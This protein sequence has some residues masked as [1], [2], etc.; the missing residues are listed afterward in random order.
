LPEASDGSGESERVPVLICAG[1]PYKYFPEHDA[2]LVDIARR[3]GRCRFV[4]FGHLDGARTR[5]LLTRAGNAFASAGLRAEDFLELQ[6]WMR[7][8][9]FRRFMR[10][11]DVYLD[12]IGFSGFNTVLQALGSGLPVITHRGEFMRGRFGSGIL[13]SLSA[14]PLIADTPDAYAEI[15]ATIVTDAAARSH[16]QAHFARALPQ[17]YG[18]RGSVEAFQSF[19]LS[20]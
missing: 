8:A 6:P 15:A 7:G 20:L 9:D 5:R 13:E 16:W 11:A 14:Q 1:T 3:L 19:L 4:F 10:S 17:L 12:T 2:V 18:D